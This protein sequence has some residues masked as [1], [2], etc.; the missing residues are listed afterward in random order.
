M[1]T[2]KDSSQSNGLLEAQVKLVTEQCVQKLGEL[3]KQSVEE[4]QTF[5]PIVNHPYL[6]V[7][8]TNSV[9]KEQLTLYPNAFV[10]LLKPESRL[11]M[12][13]RATEFNIDNLPR[14]VFDV[15]GN[16]TTENRYDSSSLYIK[17]LFTHIYNGTFP[18][19][20]EITVIHEDW[21]ST[22]KILSTLCDCFGIRVYD[23]FFNSLL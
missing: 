12:I 6:T 9:T 7:T 10:H 4:L 20:A 23:H 8:I 15:S 11:F 22:I 2:P 13:T 19:V 18:S 1:D 17:L 5:L 14:W 21:R 16:S 3:L